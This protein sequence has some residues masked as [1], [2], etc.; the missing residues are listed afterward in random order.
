MK[1]CAPLAIVCLTLAEGLASAQPIEVVVREATGPT[2]SS[3][4]DSAAS[5]VVRGERLDR[6]GADSADVLSTVPGVQVTRSGSS[7]DLATASI[8]GASSAQTP[9]YLAGIRLNDDVTGTADLSLVP[10]W[11]LDR[12]EVFRGSAPEAADRLGIGGAVF[13]EPRLPRRSAVGAGVELGS[14]GQLATWT[15]AELRAAD[16]ASLVVV[17]RAFAENDY[18]YESDRGQSFDGTTVS[19]TRRNADVQT[20]DA[21]VMGR[22]ELAPSAQLRW[23][24]N[25]LERTQ[26]EPGLGVIQAEHSRSRTR[27]VLAGVTAT[28]PC[29][30]GERCRL[31]LSSSALSAA[32][33]TTDPYR[34]LGLG[35]TT[36]TSRG[37][38]VVSS[39]RV[40]TSPAS[41]L[42]VVV[43]AS[44][45]VELLA[46]TSA[47]AATLDARRTVTRVHAALNYRVF[48]AFGVGALVAW[49]CHN[50][51]SALET[52]SCDNPPFE[53]RLSAVHELSENAQLALNAGSYQR[54]PTLGELYGVA[55]LVRGNAELAPERGVSLDSGIRLRGAS[56]PLRGGLDV[57][58]FVRYTDDLIA[59]RRAAQGYARPYNTSRARVAGAELG[60]VGNAFDHVA[61][62]VALT[63]LD[64]RDISDDR[65]TVQNLL[66]YRARLQLFHRLEWYAREPA[67]QLGLDRAALGLSSFYRSATV[68]DPAGLIV[69]QKQLTFDVDL[70]LRFAEGRLAARAAV[71]NVLGEQRR[72]LLNYPLPGRSLHGSLEGWWW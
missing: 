11:M 38:R 59:Y 54:V 24:V 60:A 65:A 26:G 7:S 13:F 27:R 49:S 37:D 47:R 33:T 41:D 12:V 19:E 64:P 51:A 3:R 14:Y 56:G 17:R 53:G 1:R 36:T 62:E 23:F 63:V 5:S 9:V 35:A 29:T 21:W 72:D 46:L 31:E 57:F 61:S 8:R 30:A 22:L 40:S 16:A 20:G 66:P 58:G 67:P 48:P 32:S 6:P 45:E 43:G 2:R 69:N 18:T 71:E 28:V 39:A 4:D 15:G 55:P 70:V 50:T 52:R 10:L 25:G 42:D 44:G 34:E 68:A